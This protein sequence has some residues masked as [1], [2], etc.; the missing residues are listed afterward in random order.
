MPCL[1]RTFVCT[2]VLALALAGPALAKKQQQPQN[3]DFGAVTCKEF[4]MEI[5][6]ADEDS[7][8]II[9]MWL[10]GYLSGVSGDTKL[11]WKTLETFSGALM[12]ACAKK[13]GQ[14]VLDVARE[15][16]IN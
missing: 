3:I 6:D 12:E 9:L 13:P 15:V 8:G 16:G 11:N 10:D 1:L 7:A 2:A 4:V 14:K 5:A